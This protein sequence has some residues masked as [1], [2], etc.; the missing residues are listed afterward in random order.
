MI[1]MRI[2]N[3][4]KLV[5]WKIIGMGV[6]NTNMW[7]VAGIF[8]IF[9]FSF[10]QHGAFLCAN[11]RCIREAWRCDQFNDCGDASDEEDCHRVRYWDFVFVLYFRVLSLWTILFTFVFSLFLIY[12]I[13]CRYWGRSFGPSV[14]LGMGCIQR[15]GYVLSVYR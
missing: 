4:M 2:T 10:L 15:N 5:V 11:R 1:Y 9:Q 8:L 3:V 13:L 12:E 6:E 14:G 7:Y